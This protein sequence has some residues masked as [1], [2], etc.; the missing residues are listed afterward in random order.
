M[1][2]LVFSLI[3]PIASFAQWKPAEKCEAVVVGL[4]SELDVLQVKYDPNMAWLT[5]NLK[6][7]SSFEVDYFIQT[8]EPYIA[9]RLDTANFIGSIKE[10]AEPFSKPF[11]SVDLSRVDHLTIFP[12]PYG[13]YSYG[14]FQAKNDY[15]IAKF[16]FSNRFGVAL[17][18][19]ISE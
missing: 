10:L 17:C 1:S 11:E 7:D 19:P 4:G 5:M 15:V 12:D 2:L 9:T 18:K 13:L 6:N 16:I 14:Y 8:E 3:L